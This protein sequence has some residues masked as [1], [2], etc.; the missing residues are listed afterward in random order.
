[1]YLVVAPNAFKGS[2]S[3]EEA[4]CSIAEGLR[5]SALS[6]QL[7][8]APVADGGDGTATLIAKKM[9]C[10]QVQVE[11]EDPLGRMV[12]AVFGWAAGE[13]TAIIEMSEASGFRLMQ[14]EELNPLLTN[15]KGTG[16]LI[17]AALDM[18]AQRILLGVGG[19]ATVDGGTGLLQ[20][21]GIRFLDDKGNEIIE[22]PGELL[23]LRT[24]DISTLDPRL[25]LCEIVVLCDV[26]N[27][28]LGDNGA[29]AV[30]GPQKGAS[31]EGVIR[32]EKCLQHLN[33]VTAQALKVE[34]S[35]YVYGGA[36]GGVAAGL[37]A[38]IN[39]RFINSGY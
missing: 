11:V 32:L 38:Y 10:T 8:L 6:C 26:Q 33:K 17:Q 1:M 23:K 15:T 4:A 39:A 3:A 9:N 14:K 37:A 5:L 16:Q 30:F 36:A 12:N 29:A 18:G 19:S 24:I 13:K 7:A 27:T 35:S 2:L 28:L 22:L 20:A 21:L 31:E 25:R 34:M